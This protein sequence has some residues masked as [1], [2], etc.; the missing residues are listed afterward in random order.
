MPTYS[1]K[2]EYCGEEFDKIKKISER[3]KSTCKCGKEAVICVT[4][5]RGIK[6][7]AFEAGRMFV[8]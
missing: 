2:C 8:R 3:E 6:N 5:P 4:P 7:G 1:Y